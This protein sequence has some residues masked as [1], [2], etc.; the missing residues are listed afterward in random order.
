VTVEKGTNEYVSYDTAEGWEE[1]GA[2]AGAGEVVSGM[3]GAEEGCGVAFAQESRMPKQKIKHA[4]TSAN[5]GLDGFSGVFMCKIPPYFSARDSITVGLIVEVGK[6][7]HDYA[8]LIGI[9]Q[10]VFDTVIKYF[11]DKTGMVVIKPQF[12]E[13][14]EFAANG[15]AVVRKG[16]LYGY[17]DKTGALS[18]QQSSMMRSRLTN[19]TG[20][21]FLPAIT[22]A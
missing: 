6:F 21:W 9:K 12:D 2:E 7:G 11:D 10:T 19:S 8:L 4:I 20:R 14:Q 13:V 16:D 15:L 18:Y 3:L 22:G 5:R 17:I 1:S